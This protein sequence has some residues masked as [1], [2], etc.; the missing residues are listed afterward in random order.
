M[1]EVRLL[2]QFDVRLN[3]TLVIIPSRPAQ[4]L[5]AYLMLNPGIQHRREM[6]AGLFWPDAAEENARRSLRQALW[7]TL[8]SGAHGLLI[9]VTRSNVL[10]FLP[11]YTLTDDQCEDAVRILDRVLAR[12]AS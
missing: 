12:F 7:Q 9:N 3:G 11:P 6:L 5:L 10:R 2:G 1:L 8:G 4:S